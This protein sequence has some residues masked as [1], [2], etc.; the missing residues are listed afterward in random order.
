MTR[1]HHHPQLFEGLR[2]MLPGRSKA[3]ARRTI[4]SWA[5]LEPILRGGAML[6]KTYGPGGPVYSA[7]G[8]EVSPDIAGRVIGWKLVS[9]ADTDLFHDSG[10]AQTWRF[11]R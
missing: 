10:N 5:E 1:R 9:P 8:Y 6:Q 11:R 4:G 3:R 7:D 2:A